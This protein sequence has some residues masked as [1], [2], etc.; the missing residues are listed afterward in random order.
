[1][2]ETDDTLSRREV[3]A[4]IQEFRGYIEEAVRERDEKLFRRLL[5]SRVDESDPIWQIAWDLW[6]EALGDESDR[7]ATLRRLGAQ[8]AS[9]RPEPRG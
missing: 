8:R 9:S 6:R 4:E 2:A 3:A 7:V 5:R 1:M